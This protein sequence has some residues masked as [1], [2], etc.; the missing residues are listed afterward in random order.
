MLE[1]AYLWLA[2]APG[3]SDFWS[4]RFFYPTENAAAYSDLFLS[5]APIYGV[6]RL[7]HFPPD[8]SFQIWM[9]TTSALNYLV[10]L[11]FLHRRFQMSLPAACAGAFL[12]AF[13]APRINQMSH[14][15]LLP[16]F[17]GLITVDAL[18]GIFGGGKSTGRQRAGLW[19]A[20][21]LGLVAQFYAGFYLGWFLLLA[22]VIATAVALWWSST[23]VALLAALRRDFLPLTVAFLAACVLMHPLITHYLR[24]SDAVGT[25]DYSD[26]SPYLVNWAALVN[27]GRESWLWGWTHPLG[28]DPPI[29]ESEKRLGIGLIT[30]LACGLGLFWNS[31]SPRIR[32]LVLVATLLL[33]CVSPCRAAS[34]FGFRCSSRCWPSRFSFM[35][36]AKTGLCHGL[37]RP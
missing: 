17:L 8:T 33:L 4:P 12:F 27:M 16:Q 14:Q 15:Q 1:H 35:S 23:R 6:G 32:L 28:T 11:H 10:A 30:M 34:S 9:I 31:D 3:H 25:R 13:G 29:H 19:L 37:P 20:A 36:G 22:I 24:A 18:C 2:G 21:S 26:V 7:L 5:V